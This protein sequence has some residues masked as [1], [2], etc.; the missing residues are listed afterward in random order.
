M[1]VCAVVV[2]YNRKRLLLECLEALRAQ[3]RPV[4]ELILV[5]NASTDGTAELLEREGWLARPEVRY[6]RLDENLGSS[7]GFAHAF[8][9]AVRDSR[10]GWLWAMDDDAAPTPDCLRLLLDSPPAHDAATACVCP[11]VVYPDGSLNGVMRADFRRR[12]RPLPATRYRPGEYPSIGVSSFVGP[13][14]RM[15]AVRALDPPKAEFFVWGDDVEYSLRLRRL[16]E[17]RLVPESVIVH[18]PAS[19]SH[20]N[21]RSRVWNAVLPLQMH[22]TPLEGFWQNL[23]GLRNYLWTKR[24]YEGQSAVSA[25]G[26]T[27]QFVV[28][29]L[30]YDDRPLRRIPWILRYA[31]DGRRGRFEN[32]APAEWREMVRRGAV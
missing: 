8:A 9:A 4:D 19:Q 2:T 1:T 27:L 22:P 5:D 6:L 30:L 13:L 26:T 17:I 23:C 14:Y 28:K 24:H 18:K 11:K 15:E 12:L 7:G 31:R 16:G 21:L 10:A 3:T 32:I 20:S 25:A 29:H